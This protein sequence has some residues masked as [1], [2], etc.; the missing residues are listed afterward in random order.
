MQLVLP[1]GCLV[2]GAVARWAKVCRSTPGLPP[3]RGGSAANGSKAGDTPSR[4][5][6]ARRRRRQRAVRGPHAVPADRVLARALRRAST[7]CYNAP[8]RSIPQM[9]GA[10]RSMAH[11]YEILDQRTRTWREQG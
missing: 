9:R 5:P 4:P 6:Y 1:I 8:G 10:P 7:V 3:Q 2:V 11:L